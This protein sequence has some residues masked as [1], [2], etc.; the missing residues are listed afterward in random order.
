MSGGD[1]YEAQGKT[2]NYAADYRESGNKRGIW[3]G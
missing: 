1:V 2:K 3:T